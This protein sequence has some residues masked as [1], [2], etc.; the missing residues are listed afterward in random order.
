MPFLKYACVASAQISTIGWDLNLEDFK[1]LSIK[2]SIIWQMYED[3]K[4][5]SVG[6]QISGK[7]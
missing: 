3:G 2:N 7:L 6:R 1:T 4:V 5:Q